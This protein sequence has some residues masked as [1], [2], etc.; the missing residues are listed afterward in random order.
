MRIRESLAIVMVLFFLSSCIKDELPVP[1]VPLADALSGEACLTPTY[2]DQ[3]YFDLGTNSIVASNEKVAWDL[4]IRSDLNEVFVKMNSSRLMRAALSSYTDMYQV[5][6]TLSVSN[7]FLVDVSSGNIDSLAIDLTEL[8][9][10]VLILDMGYNHFGVHLGIIKLQ[11][12]SFTS[13]GLSIRYAPLSATSV[14]S[15]EL[16][17][18]DPDVSAYMSYVSFLDDQQVFMEP[19]LGGYD[20]LFTQYTIYFPDFDL[21]YLAVGALSAPAGV[22]VAQLND[23]SFDEV[24]LADSI[25]SVFSSDLDVIGY[26]W[27]EYEFD[28]NIYVTDPSKVFLIQEG[29]GAYYKLH[30]TDFYNDLGQKGCPQFEVVAF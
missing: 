4:A 30:F 6:D 17:V 5:S 11:V 8:G 9:G 24:Q 10:Q 29:S 3:V 2:R 25:Y 26:D 19:V 13:S 12:E 1:A 21:Y 18:I 22:R 14:S 23:V 20:L 16:V 7:E 15:S 28:Q 27:K